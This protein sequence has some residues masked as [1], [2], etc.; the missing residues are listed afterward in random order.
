MPAIAAQELTTAMTEQLVMEWYEALDQHAPVEELVRHV[1][2]DGLV[3]SFPEGTLEG[4]EAFRDWY[5]TVTHR[6]FD[7]V[8]V[9]RSATI[10]P[11]AADGADEAGAD[12]RVVQVIVNWQTRVWTPPASH[13]QWLGFDAHQTWTVA[14]EDGAARIRSYAVDRLLPMPGSAAL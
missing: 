10:G 7:E 9:V 12:V 8:H 6:F 13:S 3:M 11:R 5:R 2:S 14:L 4:V 1:V